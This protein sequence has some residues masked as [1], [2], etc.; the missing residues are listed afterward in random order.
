MLNI[1]KGKV[2]LFSTLLKKISYFVYCHF[3]TS[4]YDL[5]IPLLAFFIQKGYRAEIRARQL[6]NESFFV[7]PSITRVSVESRAGY[8]CSAIIHSWLEF[9]ATPWK[10]S[11][12]I[13][14]KSRFT[15]IEI[16]WC[17]LFSQMSR[18]CSL[19]VILLFSDHAHCTKWF[20]WIFSFILSN[21]IFCF[22]F[23]FRRNFENNEDQ[24]S[25][26]DHCT[27]QASR[28][29]NPVSPE[30]HQAFIY[31]VCYVKRNASGIFETE[32]FFFVNK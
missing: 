9:S 13:C 24:R 6:K 2:L 28:P 29:G 30:V 15:L 27:L 26:R 19:F 23:H 8:H 20:N 31:A 25:A 32:S 3:S 4:A 18:I 21:M 10:H 7:M 12:L 14:L 16:S 17:T 1:N 11:A 5:P 22:N